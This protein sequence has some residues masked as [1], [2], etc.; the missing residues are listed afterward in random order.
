MVD[1][2]SV[3]QRERAVASAWTCDG[4]DVETF[5][6]VAS[7]ADGNGLRMARRA[8]DRGRQGP[9]FQRQPIACK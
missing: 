6:L 1:P 8:I 2:R 5:C 3:C 4:A 9:K 7:V